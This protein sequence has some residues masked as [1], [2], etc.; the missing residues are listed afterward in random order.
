MRLLKAATGF[1]FR[2]AIILAAYGRSFAADIINPSRS[3]FIPL[4]NN[5]TWAQTGNAGSDNTYVFFPISG[6]ACISVQNNNPTNPH[7]YTIT[8]K[9]T[10]DATA[11]TPSSSDGWK[12][13]TDGSA[14]QSVAAK[15]VN[16]F[17]DGVAGRAK[18]AV[19]IS[20]TTTQAGTP[21]TMSLLV[22][23]SDSN[24][25]ASAGALPVT[26]FV[27]SF[28]K[29]ATD[30]D[31]GIQVVPT[32][33]TALSASTIAVSDWW[34]NNTTASAVTLTVTDTAGHAYTSAFSIPA[35]SIFNPFFHKGLIMQG[36]KWQA[37]T[38]S[39]LNCQIIGF[40]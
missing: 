19:I 20:G 14:T 11:G 5:V 15:G 34:C 33:L 17:G 27:S 10:T 37:G 13:V 40:Q 18:V 30:Y 31:S 26:L 2:L 7:T 16:Q 22:G 1:I 28:I 24:S 6:L 35:N 21:D 3:E 9:S 8:V 38:S 39:A 4:A 23:Q 29:F 32:M 25:C 36:I 12:W